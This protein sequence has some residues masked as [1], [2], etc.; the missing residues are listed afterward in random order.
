MYIFIFHSKRRKKWLEQI[1]RKGIL[2]MDE[3][4]KLSWSL[5]CS[6]VE[7]WKTNRKFVYEKYTL[8]IFNVA[9]A[10]IFRKQIIIL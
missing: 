8:Y 6:A 1:I 7:L 10:I 9:N 4:E 5:F 2:I 3:Q